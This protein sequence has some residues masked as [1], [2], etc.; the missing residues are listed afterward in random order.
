MVPVWGPT[1][2]IAGPKTGPLLAPP[3]TS[4]KNSPREF[5]SPIASGSVKPLSLSYSVCSW[6]V[7][8]AVL[9]TSTESA[10]R[11]SFTICS[12]A[13][14]PRNWTEDAIC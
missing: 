6:L 7:S 5:V 10:P 11:R 3:T 9:T 13:S 8:L 1:I 4:R 12:R 14:R 2:T